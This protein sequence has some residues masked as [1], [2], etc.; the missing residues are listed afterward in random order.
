[1]TMNTLAREICKREGLKKQTDIAQVKEILRVLVELIA[2]EWIDDG[3]WEPT[4]DITK[5]IWAAAEKHQAK[6][7]KRLER[8]AK[9]G[10][11][12]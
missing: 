8:E 5:A 6:I 2:E 9:R 3:D 10:S 1:M 4:G 7:L 11:G 12:R